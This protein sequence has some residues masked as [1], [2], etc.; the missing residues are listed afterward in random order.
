MTTAVAPPVTAPVAAPVND[1]LAVLHALRAG[2]NLPWKT[3]LMNVVACALRDGFA[4]VGYGFVI[5]N[6]YAPLL[7]ERQVACLW[8]LDMNDD[9]EIANAAAESAATGK[10]ARE[11]PNIAVRVKIVVK[12]VTNVSGFGMAEKCLW[13][14]LAMMVPNLEAKHD[15]WLEKELLDKSFPMAG[16]L[17]EDIVERAK[18]L[19]FGVVAPNKR[20]G[21]LDT[22]VELADYVL[23]SMAP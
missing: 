2:L 1:D 17:P 16:L 12:E 22:A 18:S 5:C 15:A 3:E 19:L 11:V 9:V 10:P 4:E 21:L 7:H 8:S 14:S 20:Q 6:T 23:R 13:C